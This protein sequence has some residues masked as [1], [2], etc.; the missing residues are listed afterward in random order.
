M[1]TI[2]DKNIVEVGVLSNIMA[3]Y[4]NMIGKYGKKN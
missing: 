1:N 4:E 3:L 2:K